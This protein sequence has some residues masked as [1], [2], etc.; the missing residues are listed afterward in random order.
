MAAPTLAA[1]AVQVDTSRALRR[2]DELAMLVGVVM[3]AL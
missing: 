1:V 2:P 3:Q